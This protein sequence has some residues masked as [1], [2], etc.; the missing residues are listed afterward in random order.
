MISSPQDGQYYPWGVPVTATVSYP[1]SL[2][3]TSVSYFVD[4]GLVGTSAQPP[5]AIRF[6]PGRHGPTVIRAIAQTSQGQI[7][8]TTTFSVQ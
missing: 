8:T 4:G 7:E 6:N 5:F 2:S 1:S 3:V